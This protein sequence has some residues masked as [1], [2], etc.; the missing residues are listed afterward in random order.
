MT[1]LLI[2]N[3]DISTKKKKKSIRPFGL[4]TEPILKEST[5]PLNNIHKSIL[6]QI[7]S[8]IIKNPKINLQL[9]QLHKTKTHPFTYQEKH[10]NILQQHP[11]YLYVY[12]DGSKDNN[13][14]TCSSLK[15]NNKNKSSSNG[16]FYFHS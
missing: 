15:Q 14:T 12:T 9:N 11:D 6:P 4:C 7:P 1:A 5:I 3:A 10:Q 2:Q 13:K 16:K 8:W